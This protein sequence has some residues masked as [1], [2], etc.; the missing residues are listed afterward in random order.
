MT[1]RRKKKQKETALMMN[2][3]EN[4]QDFVISHVTDGHNR[5]DGLD[6]LRIDMYNT[7]A[8]C[9]LF[10]SPTYLGLWQYMICTQHT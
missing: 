5:C 3:I 9:A 10:E 7:C 4:V 8:Q 1:Q 2:S 6:N